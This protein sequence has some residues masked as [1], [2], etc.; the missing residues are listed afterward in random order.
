MHGPNLGGGC[1][2]PA[3]V[4]QLLVQG[5][6]STVCAQ[7]F[8]AGVVFVPVGFSCFP[9]GVLRHNSTRGAAFPFDWN[10]SPLAAV[11]VAIACALR[12]EDAGNCAEAWLADVRFDAPSRCRIDLKGLPWVSDGGANATERWATPAVVFAAGANGAKTPMLRLSGFPTTL[13]TLSPRTKRPRSRA[14]WAST[15][16]ASAGSHASCAAAA[17]RAS[18]LSCTRL[19]KVHGERGHHRL[20]TVRLRKRRC[21]RRRHRFRNGRNARPRHRRAA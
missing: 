11:N 5:I 9:A 15:P 12:A 3:C 2:S 7:L 21:R 17:T 13:S 14:S 6:E 20:A 1:A 18:I 16:V 10:V 4:A 19:S 8:R